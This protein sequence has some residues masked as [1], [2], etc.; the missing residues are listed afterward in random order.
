M[1]VFGGNDKLCAK[2]T[3]GKLSLSNGRWQDMWSGSFK[4][5]AFKTFFG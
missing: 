1:G 4:E 3:F 2:L 5:N